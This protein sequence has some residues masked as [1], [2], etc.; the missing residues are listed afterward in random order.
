MLLLLLFLSCYYG[1][2]LLFICFSLLLHF[3]LV[4][5]FISWPVRYGL[6][7]LLVSF[8]RLSS[9]PV[10]REGADVD[11]LFGA[12]RLDGFMYVLL[13]LLAVSRFCFFWVAPGRPFEGFSF[14]YLSDFSGLRFYQLS[15]SPSLVLCP[16]RG[17]ILLFSFLA[18]FGGLVLGFFFLG[19][20]PLSIE[21]FR[22]TSSVLRS[23]LWVFTNRLVWPG[24][25]PPRFGGELPLGWV[26][27]FLSALAGSFTFSVVF[28]LIFSCPFPVCSGWVLYSYFFTS[29]VVSFCFIYIFCHRIFW[30][31]LS[32]LYVLPVHPVGTFLLLLWMFLHPRVGMGNFLSPVCSGLIDKFY[33]SWVDTLFSL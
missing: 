3:I 31:R 6:H 12:V 21:H 1:S 11:C 2:I 5:D 18:L 30:T 29:L 19:F 17:F 10:G 27:W 4:G 20:P 22:D 16:T 23:F 32:I 9:F 7:F 14:S 13:C 25:S 33:L 15:P 28:L 24:F 8:S 26:F